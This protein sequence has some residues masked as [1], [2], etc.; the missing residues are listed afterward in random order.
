MSRKR[1]LYAVTKSNWGGAQRY[2]YD[3]ATSLPPTEY[4]VAVVAGGNGALLDRLHGRGLATYSL[5]ALGRD[6]NPLQDLRSLLALARVIKL[7]QP[8]II[9]LNSPKIAGLGALVARWHRVPK[10]IFT[11]HGWAFHENRPG[12]QKL[13][14]KFFHWLT[15]LLVDE[16]ICLH[17]ADADDTRQW[18]GISDKVSLIHNGVSPLTFLY[19]DDARAELIRRAPE[20]RPKS[21]ELWIGMIGELHP[22]KGYDLMLNLATA[23]HQEYPH[24]A[25]VI[26]GDGELTDWLAQEITHRR[27]TNIVVPVGRVPDAATLLKAFDLFLL[28][29]RKE[30][31]PYVAL[32]A[33]LA[34]LALA[35]PAVGGLPDLISQPREGLLFDPTETEDA[36]AKLIPLLGN[37]LER[38]IRGRNLGNRVRDAFSTEQMV[39][40]TMALY[41]R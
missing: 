32:E 2:V 25:I 10:I 12:W 41:N 23:L 36:T 13:I 34:E 8:D 38:E 5:G 30:G 20:L 28:T 40:Q 31:L 4:E 1:I 7:F 14:I 16:V 22:N 3:L 6:I 19:R 24:L 35:A 15:A 39:S 11:N 18:R 17:Q 37:S 29:S 27:L 33:G 26:I 9:H 21:R